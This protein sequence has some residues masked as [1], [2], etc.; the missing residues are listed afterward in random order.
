MMVQ[1][2][3]KEEINF[4]NDKGEVIKGSNIYCSFKDERVNGLK[5]SKFFIRDNIQFP[6]CK[7]ND[8]INLS[9]NMKGKVE[10]I[11]KQ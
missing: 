10:F 7:L 4:S 6:E 5:T 1:L 11:F 2:L 3:G 8:T 9:F